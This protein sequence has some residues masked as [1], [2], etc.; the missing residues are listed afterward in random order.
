MVGGSLFWKVGFGRLWHSWGMSRY[1]CIP[2]HLL[3][4]HDHPPP[5]SIVN[6]S[7]DNVPFTGGNLVSYSPSLPPL[8]Y[9][10]SGENINGDK[11]TFN[12]GRRTIKKICG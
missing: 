2:L 9:F 6:C 12:R 1:P 5:D 10:S 3:C 11:S 4:R 7:S 8:S